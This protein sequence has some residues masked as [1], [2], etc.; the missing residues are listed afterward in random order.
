M[1]IEY[2]TT[3]QPRY[4]CDRCEAHTRA[5]RNA[6]TLAALNP[7]WSLPSEANGATLCPD[8]ANTDRARRVPGKSLRSMLN[9]ALGESFGAF[10]FWRLAE[11]IAA[12]ADLT[13]ADVLRMRF[14]VNGH[15][16][17]TYADIGSALGVSANRARAMVMR[18]VYRCR[19]E[20]RWINERCAAFDEHCA[21]H[22]HAD[23]EV[24]G[25]ARCRDVVA[26][27]KRRGGE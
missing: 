22:H 6:Q 25:A 9:V 13:A 16:R 11:T 24:C 10:E 8:C 26:E 18:A 20:L 1:P 21:N 12:T 2:V 15:V 4:Q 27:E 23:F 17:Q 5:E 19:A 7:G 14:A 3:Q